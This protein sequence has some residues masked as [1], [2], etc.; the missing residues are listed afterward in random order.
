MKGKAAYNEYNEPSIRRAIEYFRLAVQ[1]DSS[2]AL[3]YVGLADCFHFLEGP[4]M[5]RTEGLARKKENIERAL[6]L[7]PELGEAHASLGLWL[8]DEL[9]FEEAGAN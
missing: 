7:N 1:E 8:R 6:T 5:N 2:F 3:A 9:R 4:Y